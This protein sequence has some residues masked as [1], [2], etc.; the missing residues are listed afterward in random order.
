MTETLPMQVAAELVLPSTTAP[1][2]DSLV[3]WV[4]DY[5][6]AKVAGRAAGTVSAKK[7]DLQLFFDYLAAVVQS[8]QVD[9]WTPLI[10]RQFKAWL[11]DGEPD[12]RRAHARAYAPSSTNRILATLR[13]FAKYIQA[14]R[15][16]Q[17]GYPLEDVEDIKTAAP[18]W[19]GLGKLELSRLLAALDQVTQLS[20][21]QNQL[22]LRD[23]AVFT[24]AI[25][26]GLR[27]SEIEALDFEQYQANYLNNVRGKGENY[28][29]VYVPAGARTDL[30]AYIERE[31]GTRAGPLFQTKTGGRFRREYIHRF[32]SRVAAQAN[33]R[34]PVS[35]QIHLHAHKLRHTSI[36][37]VHDKRGPV[38]A[39]K[40]GGHR[41][42]KQLERYATPTR[43]EV[44]QSAD[45][46][47]P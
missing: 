45:E 19:N 47:F 17:A 22:P 15:P 30:N 12:P 8:D 34:L 6:Q 40:H 28:R 26:T 9:F 20:T 35:E 2:R 1:D 31:R 42:F 18:E 21:R 5:W 41:S 32:L 36:K 29:D 39:K 33:A 7:A 4:E 27:A 43:Q 24:L 37:R 25:A 14:R 16:F 46:L 3:W 10:S 11:L 23:R 38:A 13:H 44:E